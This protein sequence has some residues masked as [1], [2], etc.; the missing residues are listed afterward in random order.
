VERPGERGAAT[1]GPSTL[2]ILKGLWWMARPLTLVANVLAWTLG[3]SIALGSGA[4]PE[5]ACIL[6]SFSAMLSVSASIHYTN[7]YADHETD[8]L[9]MRTRYSGGSGVLPSGIVPRRLAI[10]AAW[11][12]LLL[13]MGLQLAAILMGVHAWATMALLLTGAF[14]GWMYSLPPLK[15]AWRGWGEV[16]NALL[17]GTVLPMYAYATVKGRP[18]PWVA[19][20]CLPF[21]LL[22]FTNL[23]AVNWPDRH[24]DA[25]V[26]KMTLAT[27]W[28]SRRLRLAY[29]GAAATSFGVLPLLAGWAMPPMVAVASLAALPLLLWEVLTYT[30]RESPDASVYAM[31]VVM[32]V[33]ALAWLMNRPLL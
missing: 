17:G 9:T 20:A 30:R 1:A 22:V 23:M 12:S 29:G 24:A 5:P 26:G 11:A 14:W 7:E 25:V 10:R 19:A 4:A 2:G 13:G 18:D 15:L 6:W 16:D 33:Q 27:R 28:P 3:V 32:V 21:T 8:A 31:V